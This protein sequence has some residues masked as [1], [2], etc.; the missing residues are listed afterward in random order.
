MAED[1]RPERRAPLRLRLAVATTLAVAAVAAAVCGAAYL[2][3]GQQLGHEL[4]LSLIRESNRVV[5]QVRAGAA[6]PGGECAWLASPDCV[7]V[8]HSDGTVTPAPDP[9]VPPVVPG[10]VAVA[11]GERG[12]YFTDSA[13]QGLP[14]RSYVAP[15]GQGRAVQVSMRT[16]SIQHSERRIAVALVVIGGAGAV[17]AAVL[18]HAV[19]RTGLRPVA[20]LTRTAETIAATRDPGHRIDVPGRDELS[21]LAGSFNVMLGELEQALDARRQIVADASHELRTPLTGLRTNIAL[22]SHD[23]TDGQRRRVNNALSA[24][25]TEMSGLVDDV[26]ELARGDETSGEPEDVRLD[27][28]VRHCVAAARR[29]SPTTRFEVALEPCVV[30]GVPARLA[31]AVTNLLGNAAK[32][33]PPDAPVEVR[34]DGGALTVRDHGA[35]FAEVDLPHVFDRFYRSQSARGLPGSGLG[36]AIVQQVAHAHGAHAEALNAS[37]GGALLRI[38]FPTA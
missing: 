4:N 2:A 7:Q 3:V 18:G 17:L 10:A 31:R 19:A 12:A 16:D 23:L 15:A 11:K 6:P 38:R 34:L 14:F 30:R 27:E 21:R 28:I 32:F 36:L 20:R 13:S 8:V 25:I 1:R 9:Y 5:P 26:I 33:S 24:Q 37:G 22:L 35:G 29:H